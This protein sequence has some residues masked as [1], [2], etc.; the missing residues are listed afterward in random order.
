MCNKCGTEAPQCCVTATNSESVIW[1]SV[2]A[3]LHI[4]S[5]FNC[6]C[7]NGWR[8]EDL[9]NYVN[10]VKKGNMKSAPCHLCCSTQTEFSQW[11]GGTVEQ[12][13]SCC[14]C[15]PPPAATLSCKCGPCGCSDF[16]GWRAPPGL[17]SAEKLWYNEKQCFGSI[18]IESRSRSSQKSQS[19]SRKVLNPDP[20]PSYFRTLF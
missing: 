2:N 20:D 13:S 10:K 8:I 9:L 5:N 7:K 14:S 18:F 16:P 4:P 3:Q 11:C 6:W 1:Q 17:A 19:G 15:R 12:G